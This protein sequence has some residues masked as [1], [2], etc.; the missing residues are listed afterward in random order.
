MLC[1]LREKDITVEVNDYSLLFWLIE[2]II[3]SMLIIYL[4]QL[5]IGP[6]SIGLAS[7][8]HRMQY[9]I[10]ISYFL[11]S[12]KIFLFFKKKIVEIVIRTCEYRSYQVNQ[13]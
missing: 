10:M 9:K 3:Y 4:Y 8:Y 6:N 12:F 13:T 1:K 5:I 7:P 2:K 11:S